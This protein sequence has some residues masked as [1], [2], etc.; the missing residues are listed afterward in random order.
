MRQ[1]NHYEYSPV[2][3]ANSAMTTAGSKISFDDARAFFIQNL[4]RLRSNWRT[5][6]APGTRDFGAGEEPTFKCMCNRTLPV[7][8]GQIDHVAADKALRSGAGNTS[9]ASVTI[10]MRPEPGSAFPN[11]LSKKV[12]VETRGTKMVD[13]K[14]KYVLNCTPNQSG[15]EFPFSANRVGGAIP[16]G[17]QAGQDIGDQPGKTR[18]FI[19]PGWT[20]FWVQAYAD[21]HLVGL[22]RDGAVERN[23]MQARPKVAAGYALAREA[24]FEFKQFRMRETVIRRC[25][26]G[27][28]DAKN[29]SD[30]P[31]GQSFA[32]PMTLGALLSADLTNFQILCPKCNT[33]KQDKSF[34]L[35]FGKDIK[36]YFPQL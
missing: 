19:A 36:D 10:E 16:L 28:S 7:V 17:M 11:P 32:V 4:D 35:Y 1:R 20:G 8:V 24:Y 2:F 29:L 23:I 31:R 22:L 18:A 34:S 6:G 9:A 26:L 25:R 12:S 5:D 27:T 3:L 13:I 14:V 15:D 30:T 33:S 21:I